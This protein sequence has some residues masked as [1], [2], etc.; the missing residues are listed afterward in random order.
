MAKFILR[1][2]FVELNG[3]NFSDHCSSVEVSLKKA[4]VDTTNFSGG[5]KEQQA[6]LKDDEFT[7]NLQQDYNPAETDATLYPLYNN[8][9]EFTVKVRP[10]AGAIST[11]NPEYSATCILLE[12]QPISG[13][14]GELSETKVKLP[15]QRAGITR[16]TS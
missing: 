15:T 1:D 5:G 10:G 14:V 13:K 9:T 12:Y 11:S 2:C 3:V 7:L 8:E 4:S 16:A 6:G